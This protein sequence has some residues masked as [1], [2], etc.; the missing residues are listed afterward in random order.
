MSLSKAPTAVC[1]SVRTPNTSDSDPMGM[2]RKL[3]R[4][5]KMG[6]GMNMV[7]KA[8]HTCEIGGANKHGQEAAQT[9][10]IGV[11]M[12]MVKKPR[13]PVVGDGCFRRRQQWMRAEA[14]KRSQAGEVSFARGVRL[15][16]TAC[17][18]PNMLLQGHT[19]AAAF[20]SAMSLGSIA[21]S[22]G[23]LTL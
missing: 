10:A 12:H 7:N 13:R 16:M 18:V 23:V 20:S 8:A 17:T 1:A 15:M 4:P 21:T 14:V 22:D 3:R 2:V 19:P 5:G 6:V 9:C 11:P